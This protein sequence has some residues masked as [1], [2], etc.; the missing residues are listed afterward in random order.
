MALD[1]ILD[2]AARHAPGPPPAIRAFAKPGGGAAL[3]GADAG[4]GVPEADR[5]RIF[6]PLERPGSARTPSD[7]AGGFGLGPPAARQAM[8]A[9]GGDVSGA[10]R[11]DGRPGA[12]FTLH[13]PP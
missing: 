3:E 9:M 2:N 10:A 7:G 8:R 1:N 5:E 6:E 11:R 12:A 13:F 4:S